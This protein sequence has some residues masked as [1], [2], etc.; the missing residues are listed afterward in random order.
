MKNKDKLTLIKECLKAN[1]PVLTDI[2]TKEDFPLGTVLPANCKL[3]DLTGHYEKET[4]LPPK[5]YQE[6]LKNK[7]LIIDSLDTISLE[8]QLKFIEILKYHQVS[9]FEIPLNTVI[10]ITATKINSMTINKEI[11]SLV[12][13]IE[14][15]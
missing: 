12:A 9:T 4:Y 8:E 6:L 3:E 2:L 14:G 10:I 5:W 7:I 1:I 13:H 15:E 11:Y